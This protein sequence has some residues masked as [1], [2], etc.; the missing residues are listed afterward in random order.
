MNG[1]HAFRFL[2]KNL[3]I[4]LRLFPVVT[5]L[6]AVVLPVHSEVLVAF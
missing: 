6:T 5:R 1:T 2:T 4:E 3:V